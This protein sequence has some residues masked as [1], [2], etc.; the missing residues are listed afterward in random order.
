LE[1]DGLVCQLCGL[2][3]LEPEVDHIVP[4]GRAGYTH[5][6]Q[7]HQSNLRTLCPPCHRAEHQFKREAAR[8]LA[9]SGRVFHVKQ[10]ALPGIAA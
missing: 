3:T 5:G 6:C 2:S 4:V 7:H 8:V 1:R 10:L 9:A